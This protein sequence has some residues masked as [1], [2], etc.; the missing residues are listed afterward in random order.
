MAAEEYLEREADLER[1]SWRVRRF[2]LR[3]FEEERRL[4]R[5]PGLAS[6]SLGGCAKDAAMSGSALISA[7]ALSLALTLALEIGFFYLTGKRD[8]RDLLLLVL[9]NVVTNPLAVLFFWILRMYSAFHPVLI[10]A[11]LELVAALV[12]GWYY[13]RYG[14]AIARP[15][16][17]ALAV[18]AFSFGMGV[19]IQRLL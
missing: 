13:E 3:S 16:L 14:Q 18:N 2:I 10:I 7:L 11:P 1:L 17:F 12:E 9:V 4:S 6:A 15:W 5:A 19:L 8:K